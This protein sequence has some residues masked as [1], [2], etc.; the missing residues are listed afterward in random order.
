M[1]DVAVTKLNYFLD[2]SVFITSLKICTLIIK[3]I[4]ERGKIKNNEKMR[5][6]WNFQYKR[7]IIS[8]ELRY[9][10]FR[11]NYCILRF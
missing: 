4:C 6:E 3:Y 11:Q 5:R 9:L 8:V 10:F 2:R 7:L 1:L